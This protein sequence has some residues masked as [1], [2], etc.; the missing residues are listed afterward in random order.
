M[1]PSDF[2]WSR[3]LIRGLGKMWFPL[4]LQEATSTGGGESLL[5]S[6]VEELHG[7]FLGLQQYPAPYHMATPKLILDA[8]Q[9]RRSALELPAEL[10]LRANLAVPQ[11]TLNVTKKASLKTGVGPFPSLPGTFSLDVDYSRMVS[12]SISFGSN[13]HIKY[14]PTDFLSRLYNSVKGDAAKV[15]KNLAI[16]IDDNYIVDQILVANEFTVTF[17]SQE[18]FD[19]EFQAKLDYLNTLQ[20]VSG[21]ATFTFD[22]QKKKRVTIQIKGGP[23]YLLALKVLDW[24]DLG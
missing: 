13:T 4:S 11:Q 24:D 14:I 10:T 20:P 6:V 5:G 23:D 1:P 15:D 16:R 18:E 9:K 21:Q 8:L 17:E 2:Y 3:N 7:G 12:V 22:Q 19:A